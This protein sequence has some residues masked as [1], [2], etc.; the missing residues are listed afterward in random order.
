MAK[1]KERVRLFIAHP[2]TE[3]VLVVLIIAASATVVLE[4]AFPPTSTIRVVLVSTGDTIAMLFVAELLLRFWIA[5]KKR[6]FFTR[7][8]LDILAVLPLARPLRLLRILMLLR[9]FRAG[10]LMNRRLREYA[11]V[12]RSTLNE[13]TVLST[14]S[15]TIVLVAAVVIDAY[16]GSVCGG[17]GT[18]CTDLGSMRESTWYAVF[19]M[20]G[21]EPIGGQPS[22]EL[23][24]AITL[25]LMLGG[26]AIFGVFIGAVS[27]TM[28][29]VLSQRMEVGT[30]DLDELSD[31]VVVCG[32]NPAGPIMLRELFARDGHNRAVVLVT[33]TP[34]DPVNPADLGLRPELVYHHTGDYTRVE[35]LEQVGIHQANAAIL[36]T[37][38]Q[39]VRSD[40]DRDAR[41]VLAALT[42][43]RIAP[44]IFCCAE[45][46]NGEHASLLHMASVEE[47]VIR[48]WYAGVIIGS[49]GRN[50]GL[51]GVLNDILSSS[52]GNAFQRLRVSRR[53]HGKTA[54]QLHSELKEHYNAILVSW[55]RERPGPPGADGQPT[56]TRQVKVNPSVDTRVEEGDH[57]VLIANDAVEL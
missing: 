56:L 7:Y 43:E 46:T 9:L 47:V 3:L 31:H 24:R 42:I 13:M 40:A 10:V 36:L 48:D 22:S 28:M 21:G 30:M 41:T 50:R 34:E 53:Q 15:V 11:G 17:V 12:L 38:T 27:A 49:M 35:V 54:G 29:T 39:V 16:A 18:E 8:W 6:R 52:E 44:G 51:S 55:E 32:W 37:D 25:V 4:P 20:V 23:G 1:L 14:I 5:P 19:T 57:L 33:E 26:L 2:V 45:L